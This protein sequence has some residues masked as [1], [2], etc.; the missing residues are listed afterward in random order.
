MVNSN[1][2]ESAAL[3]WSFR[4]STARLSAAE[5]SYPEVIGE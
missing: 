5:T 3:L 1:R 4:E 2:I